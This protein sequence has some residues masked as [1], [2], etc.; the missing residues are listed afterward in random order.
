MPAL[1]DM[2]RVIINVHFC[3]RPPSYITLRSKGQ[4]ASGGI[5]D[6]LPSTLPRHWKACG[7][8]QRPPLA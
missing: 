1:A 3:A 7:P 4:E 6:A 2:Q 8:E 5:V